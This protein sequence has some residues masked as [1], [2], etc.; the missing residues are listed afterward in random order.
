MPGVI[1]I[2]LRG[3]PLFIYIF[4]SSLETSLSHFENM[5]I[6]LNSGLSAISLSLAR[7]H[8]SPHPAYVSV[9]SFQLHSLKKKQNIQEGLA[10]YP[11]CDRN[12][13][14]KEGKLLGVISLPQ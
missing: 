4:T 5:S 10:L 14:V 6:N 3:N 2:H 13:E 7:I 11:N 1:G 12:H 9:V 8:V